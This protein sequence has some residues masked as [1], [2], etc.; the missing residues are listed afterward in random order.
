MMNTTMVMVPMGSEMMM[1]TVK[2]PMS[3]MATPS[4]PRVRQIPGV[5]YEIDFGGAYVLIE[6][7]SED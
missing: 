6:R 5:G 1:V 2:M 3:M 4:S 7:Q